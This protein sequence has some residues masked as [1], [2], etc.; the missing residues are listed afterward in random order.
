MEFIKSQVAAGIKPQRE[1]F[2]GEESLDRKFAVMIEALQHHILLSTPEKRIEFEQ[3]VGF[4]PMFPVPLLIRL[5]LL[6]HF[7]NKHHL[8][9]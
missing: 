6:I 1:H 3:K 8:D 7:C 5:L 4:I 2:W 9:P